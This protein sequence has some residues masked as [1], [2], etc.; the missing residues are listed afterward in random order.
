MKAAVLALVLLL[1]V[2]AF[3]DNGKHHGRCSGGGNC[4]A[5]SSCGYCGNCAG[6]GGICSVCH[7]ELFTPEEGGTKVEH[8]SKPKLKA[9]KK[10]K[11]PTAKPRKKH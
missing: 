3:A 7:P 6:A 11:K 9:T 4:Y 2:P 5:C 10:P 1:T 8:K